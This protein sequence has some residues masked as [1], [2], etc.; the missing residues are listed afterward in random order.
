MRRSINE[1][2][3]GHFQLVWP[4]DGDE[5]LKFSI[6]NNLHSKKKQNVT[7]VVEAL[8]DSLSIGSEQSV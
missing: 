2:V 3:F 7:V 6:T 8:V 5:R 4:L 1:K